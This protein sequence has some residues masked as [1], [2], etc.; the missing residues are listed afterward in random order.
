LPVTTAN[1][2][3]V[4]VAPAEPEGDVSSEMGT[5]RMPKPQVVQQESW[6]LRLRMVLVE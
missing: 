6:T 2:E 5:A 3:A 1:V 4:S